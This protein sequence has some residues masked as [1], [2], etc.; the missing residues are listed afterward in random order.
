MKTTK[1]IKLTGAMVTIPV[2]RGEEPG[3]DQP[4]EI[5]GEFH[6]KPIQTI[7]EAFPLL[8]VGLVR[9]WFKRNMQE[10]MKTEMERALTGQLPVPL[11][12]YTDKLKQSFREFIKDWPQDK[13]T[14]LIPELA[15]SL[16]L[17]RLI[18]VKDTVEPG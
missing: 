9:D 15:V 3:R 4:C 7:E 6:E 8:S 10:I 13:Q 12:N 2:Q 17:Y 14:L 11:G 16:L 5:C 18:V 1:A